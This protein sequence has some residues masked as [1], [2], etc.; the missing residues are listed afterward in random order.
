MEYRVLIVAPFGRDADVIVDV[1]ATDDRRC[2]VCADSPAL[3][4]E[5]ERGAGVAIVTEESLA[6]DDARA[7]AAWLEA[8][9][10]WSDFPIVLL[11]GRL[12]GR[13][14]DA[15]IDMLERLGNVLVLERPLNSE[16]LRR[17]VASSLR[18]RARQYDSR[19]HLAESGQHLIERAR[20][21]EALE[22][23]N[24]SLESRIEERTQELASANNRLMK[25][26][27]ERAKVQAVL[28]QSQKM[29]ALGQLTGGIAHDFNN[30]LNVIMANAELLSRISADERVR[31]MAAT[32]KRATE[33]GA[34]LTAQ[35]L[36]FSRTSNLDLKSV[37]VASLLHGMR[38]IIS[39]SLGSTIAFSTTS[40]SADLWTQADAN[41]LELAVLNLAINARDAM[42]R[43]GRLSIHA[44]ERAAPDESL[45]A[46]RYVVIS[47]SD[48]GSGIDPGV[49]SRVFD[50]FFTTKPVGKGTGLGLS[51]VYGIARQAGGV[52]RIE[53][54]PGAGTTVQMW[55][56]LSASDSPET[57][58]DADPH[59][60]TQKA[61]RILVIEDDEDVR[62]MI[63]EC[64]E[65]LGHHVTCARDGQSGLDRLR[66]DAPDLMMVDYAM[67]GMNGMQ[68]LASAREMRDD[69]PVIL[70]TGYADVDLST[71]TDR[72]F[73]ALRK[74]FQLEDLARAVRLA[75]KTAS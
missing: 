47:V 50:P 64:L 46:G 41:Q 15:S 38:D 9:P 8:Q 56:P 2:F 70:A 32:T 62:T 10:A 19:R 60:D 66:A 53:S 42:P 75:L 5:L 22:R 27:H 43:G 54:E 25:E 65:A 48:S 7:L 51:Q 68:V 71:I 49:L 34:K 39:I 40:D 24:E 58:A 11:S 36:S 44:G 18:A 63:V 17:A 55:L 45:A 16:T 74:P 29:E 13:R 72:R 59:D 61:Y 14:S 21:Q 73:T 28:V 31:K 52:A 1:L 35:L 57:I 12:A 23:L 4:A 67:P 37:N 33:R 30:L 69:L 3:V 6:N 20:A 26:I